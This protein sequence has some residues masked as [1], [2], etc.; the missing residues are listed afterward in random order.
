MRHGTAPPGVV[1]RYEVF[2]KISGPGDQK[3]GKKV[4]G[5]FS[6]GE[7]DLEPYLEE[8]AYV[9]LFVVATPDKLQSL[10]RVVYHLLDEAF[11][12]AEVEAKNKDTAFSYEIFAYHDF[13]VKCDIYSQDTNNSE[14]SQTADLYVR[15][16]NDF[17]VRSSVTG[18]GENAGVT[19]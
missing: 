9:R 5:R 16:A 12:E 17:F 15:I 1:P 11:P 8:G 10:T 18:A 14:V 4:G 6:G 3:L 2:S 13:N 19:R 7:I